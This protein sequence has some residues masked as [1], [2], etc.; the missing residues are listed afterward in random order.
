RKHMRQADADAA[1]QGDVM[2]DVD[3]VADADGA[4][5]SPQRRIVFAEVRQVRR[6]VRAVAFGESCGAEVTLQASRA[7]VGADDRFAFDRYIH[8]PDVP[9]RFAVDVQWFTTF[10]D[11]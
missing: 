6:H 2:G 9:G 4:R 11:H 1:D 5:Q 7:A 10:V 3:R 8:L